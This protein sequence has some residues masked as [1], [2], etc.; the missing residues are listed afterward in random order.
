MSQYPVD[1]QQ[2]IQD[3]VN[4]LLSGPA[5]LGQNFSG[6]SSSTRAYVTGSHQ[7]PYVGKNLIKYCG[8]TSGST[9]LITLTPYTVEGINVGMTVEGPGITI[10]TTV[11][12]TDISTNTIVLSLAPY[13]DIQN[14]VYFIDTVNLYTPSY[15]LSTSEML[16]AYTIKFTLATPSSSPL[17]YLGQPVSVGG[18]SV[19]F[20]NQTYTPIGVISCTTTEIVVRLPDA[21]TLVSN[22]SGG[23]IE[24]YYTQN[25]F[26]DTS[27]FFLATDCVAFATITGATDKVYLTSVLNSQITVNGTTDSNISFELA[28]NRYMAVP[29]N[30][31]NIN[32]NFRYIFDKTIQQ[33]FTYLTLTGGSSTKDING[34]FGTIIDNPD[35]G[36]YMYILEGS[37]N[38]YSGDYVMYT[39]ELLTRC[40]TAQVVKQ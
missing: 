19:S 17:F 39:W 37:Y 21:A 40:L 6:F 25:L 3:A 32:S 10:G 2:G 34:S 28:I 8:G 11:V 35:K 36:N 29:N 4:Y 23:L 15:A 14:V 12:S 13:A 5:G 24:L 27:P 33:Q 18:V 20:Y 22:G 7:D 30:N 1:S 9:T 26:N 31:P 38:R 16:N